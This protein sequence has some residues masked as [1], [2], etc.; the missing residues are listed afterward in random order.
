MS[1]IKLFESKQV[2]MQWDEKKERW[3]FAVIDVIEII[4]E[5]DRPRKYWNDL[6]KKLNQEGYLEVSE[7][8]GQLKMI[9][10]D[11]KMRDTDVADTETLLRI[12][13]SIPS[14]K[15]EPFKRWLAMVG[16]ERIEEIEDPELA[17]RLSVPP[18]CIT[19]FFNSSGS[20]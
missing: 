12:V 8:I 5:S 2:R 9:A 4:S 15:A 3:F 13:Q 1:K 18:P 20:D 10:K 11:G 17:S 6:K 19:S 14:P 16:Y 7:K